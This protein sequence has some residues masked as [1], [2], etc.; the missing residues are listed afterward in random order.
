MIGRAEQ[1]AHQRGRPW[2][3]LDVEA[4]NLPALTLY[5][6]R[7]HEQIQ[8]ALGLRCG[9][10]G[11][12][13]TPPRAAANVRVIGRTGRKPAAEWCARHVPATI[14][15]ILPPNPT[16]LTHL[17]SLGEWLGVVRETWSVGPPTAPVGYLAA[18]WQA[19]GVRDLLFWPALDP[20]TWRE[21]MVRLLREGTAWLVA[22]G[23]WVVGAVVP[24]SVG[25]AVPVL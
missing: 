5:R 13:G 24:E 23:S 14:S 1:I 25:S 3:V 19:V 17:D 4:E 20:S 22:Q 16:L 21:D 2:A 8:S 11:S 18:Y 10:P 15:T 12:V 6:A 9:T 7:Q